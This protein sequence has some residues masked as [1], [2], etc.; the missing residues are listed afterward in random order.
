MFHEYGI[1]CII[2]DAVIVCVVLLPL[3]FC[4]NNHEFD[5]ITAILHVLLS[6]ESGLNGPIH[7]CH[8]V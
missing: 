7:F 3:Y 5:L 2:S 4:V 1:Q 8:V 6:K